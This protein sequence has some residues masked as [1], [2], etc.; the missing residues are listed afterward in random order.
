MY[1]CV[2]IIDFYYKI[3]LL[4][5]K[6]N[7]KSNQMTNMDENI[8]DRFNI[9]SISK[10]F[11]LKIAKEVGLSSKNKYKISDDVLSKFQNW[12]ED[13]LE[14]IFNKFYEKNKNKC[15]F[16]SDIQVIVNYSFGEEDYYDKLISLAP[17][18]RLVR[19]I[20]QEYTE[21]K[22]PVRI[23]NDEIK[24]LR[25]YYIEN[26]L[27]LFYTIKLTMS[28]TKN[29]ERVLNIKYFNKGVEHFGQ[30]KDPEDTPD[31]SSDEEE[32]DVKPKK[33]IKKYNYMSDTDGDKLSDKDDTKPR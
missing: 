18:K 1:F 24:Q 27:R 33:V 28:M 26:A 4:L 6:N 29:N 9:R 22:V 15:V 13:F 30:Y 10:T 5:F 12:T 23:S 8:D 11:M 32:V 31:G 20:L 19:E 21:N 17:F 3:D 16:L 7:N 14:N 25:R 2:R